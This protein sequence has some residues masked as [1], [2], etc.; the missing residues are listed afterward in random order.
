MPSRSTP[1]GND[2]L[3]DLFATARWRSLANHLSLSPRQHQVA[4]HICR[5]RSNDEIAANLGISSHTVHMHMKCLF[6]KLNVRDRVGV[7]VRLVLA[8]RSAPWRDEKT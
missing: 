3:P 6:E 4:R 2:D 1:R 7:V 8:D 5:A